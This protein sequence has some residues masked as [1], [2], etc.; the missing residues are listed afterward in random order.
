MWDA[1]GAN[2]GYDTKLSDA[3]KPDN[4]RNYDYE[5]E[6]IDTEIESYKF[7]NM[8]SLNNLF[9]G[10]A[11]YAEQQENLAETTDAKNM[12]KRIKADANIM[13]KKI[14]QADEQPKQ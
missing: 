3:Y 10:L 14:Q 12:W 2:I 7:R 4:K 11:K 1:L 9:L 6:R 5:K 8:S 13:Y